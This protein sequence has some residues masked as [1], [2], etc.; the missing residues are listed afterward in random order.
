LIVLNATAPTF[1]DARVRDAFA[2]AF[3]RYVAARFW[4]QLPTDELIP[5]DLAGGA[6]DPSATL[7]DRE[8]AAELLPDRSGDVTIAVAACDICRF[9]AQGTSFR[10][11]GLIRTFDKLGL[12]ASVELVSRPEIFAHP[13]RYD[14]LIWFDFITYQDTAAYVGAMFG[15]V[16]PGSWYPPDL[17]GQA[18]QVAQLPTG[19][20]TTAAIQLAQQLTSEHVVIPYGQFGRFELLSDRV[21]CRIYPPM[22]FGVDL[23]SLCISDQATASP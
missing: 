19:P 7:P 3:D 4:G 14:V 5:P 18:D 20:Q 2:T 12:S 9:I 8:T 23:A 10:G 16:A 1:S 17:R 13:G 6:Q 21:G 22:G 15:D 11:G